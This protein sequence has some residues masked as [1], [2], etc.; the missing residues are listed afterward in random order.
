MSR[1]RSRIAVA[2]VM[3]SSL[4]AGLAVA[5]S[6]GAT[7][8]DTTL[9]STGEGP[10]GVIAIGHSGLTGENSD[11][12]RPSEPALEN[13]WA[14]GT[15]PEVDS[16]YQ[17]LVSVWPETE[18]HVAN[19]AQGGAP[20]SALVA[21][22]HEALEVVP[23]PALVIV[24]TIDNDIRCDGTDAEHVPEFGVDVEAMLD[25]ITAASADSR[26]LMVGQLGRPSPDFIEELVGE[27][28]GFKNSLTGPA[29]CGFYDADGNLVEENFDSLTEIIESYEAE[30]ARV[31]AAVP[32]C[33][34]D[35][36]AR[37]A[38]IDVLENFSG[39]LNHLNVQGQAA[40]AEIAWPLV[41]DI[42]GV[43]DAVT[44][45]VASTTPAS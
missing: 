14:T 45:S 29:P 23:E 2:A 12:N 27:N 10:I 31:C 38:Y 36:G 17:R 41:V 37:A 3:S 30:Q 33:R 9:P 39:D 13:S 35:E 26:I 24:Q 20:A 40:A 32:Q 28:P 11:P 34:T 1:H 21:Q 22:A 4:L 25:V 42:L 44:S 19:T 16:I 6:S 8:P 43:D 5:E 18:G 7:T 15:N